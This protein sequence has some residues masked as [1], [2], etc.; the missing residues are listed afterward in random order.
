MDIAVHNIFLHLAGIPLA[1]FN[2]LRAFSST[3]AGEKYVR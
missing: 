2:N 3:P 1:P